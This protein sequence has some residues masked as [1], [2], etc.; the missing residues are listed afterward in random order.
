MVIFGCA[1][2]SMVVIN[3]I[4]VLVPDVGEN[5]SWKRSEHDTEG[6]RKVSSLKAEL[7]EERHSS[8]PLSAIMG[9]K[10]K[11]NRL[12]R[13]VHDMYI[14]LPIL[15]P[16]VQVDADP[17]LLEVIAGILDDVFDGI[18][19]LKKEHTR[20]Q[21]AAAVLGPNA[22]LGV[23]SPTL[24]PDPALLRA[25]RQREQGE[26]GN[27]NVMMAVYRGAAKFKK[28]MEKVSNKNLSGSSSSDDSSSEEGVSSEYESDDSS[29]S[30][31]SSL[32]R[33]VSSVGEDDLRDHE[34]D[35]DEDASSV[36]EEMSP[37]DQSQRDDLDKDLENKSISE[38]IDEEAG[39]MRQE[40]D[41]GYDKKDGMMAE[42]VDKIHETSSDHVRKH[43]DSQ[44][45]SVSHASINDNVSLDN[46]ESRK[47]TN[48][49][50]DAGI[51]DNNDIASD[52][53]QVIGS[54]DDSH[55]GE[56]SSNSVR[57]S[58]KSSKFDDDDDDDDN[59]GNEVV[60]RD[61]NGDHN[62]NDDDDSAV[63]ENT[64]AVVDVHINNADNNIGTAEDDGAP[65]DKLAEDDGAP[66]GKLAKKP[67]RWGWGK[68]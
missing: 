48:N 28:K 53:S 40:S 11:A 46:D 23:I 2:Q 26:P 5:K 36:E 51:S 24:W 55:K 4:D 21:H 38:E 39:G 62:D 42:N 12:R 25:E 50:I 15:S 19:V 27:M 31:R 65:V 34:G 52:H 7:V 43:S 58:R 17:W 10:R 32:H 20:G 22:K 56:N 66:I 45:S 49:N 29:S 9:L 68:K 30:G 14:P 1:A 41:G 44:R 64:D 59:K 67:S 61:I 16:N 33:S 37:V 35:V 63:G 6:G 18:W 57:I 60:T 3:K 47:P 13:V 8:I 54:D